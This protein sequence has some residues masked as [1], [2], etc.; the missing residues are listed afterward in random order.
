MTTTLA[1]AT[2]PTE[3]TTGVTVLE[4]AAKKIQDKLATD[5][6]EAVVRGQ[7]AV[8]PTKSE[9]ES[10][11]ATP[12]TATPGTLPATVAR[13]CGLIGTFTCGPDGTS[14]CAAA[15]ACQHTHLPEPEDIK[16]VEFTTENALSLM[17]N[18]KFMEVSGQS[19][20]E[21]ITET[22]EGYRT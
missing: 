6:K 15:D 16:H 11:P 10:G 5:I 1:G 22:I 4:A 21:D 19:I 7:K 9:T 8:A 14:V 20:E 13:H 3:V 2:T 18:P 12:S 17:S